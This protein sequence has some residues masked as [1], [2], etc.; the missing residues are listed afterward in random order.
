MISEYA[1]IKLDAIEYQ[2]YLNDFYE[3]LRIIYRKNRN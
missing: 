2:D 3:D 1:Y